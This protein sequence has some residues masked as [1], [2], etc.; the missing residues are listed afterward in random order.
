MNIFYTRNVHELLPRALDSL[1]KN[2][3][4]RNSRNGPVLQLPGP[5]LI[6]YECPQE[7][8]MFWPERDAN[9]FFHL[10]EA[11]WMLAG[12]E[13]VAYPAQFV[14]RISEY[15][16]DG[17]RFRGAYGFRWRHYFMGDQLTVIA[18]RLKANPDCRRQ[19]LTMWDGSLDLR[20]QSSKDL[21]CNT[22]IYFSV[23][24]GRLDMTVCNRSNDV[25]WGCLG[26][27]AV[28]M[29]VLQ[30]YMAGLIGVE[31]GK[32]H[33]FS[34]NLHGYLNTIEP[35][36]DLVMRQGEESPYVIGGVTPTPLNNGRMGSLFEDDLG[37]LG[38][39]E[40]YQSPFFKQVFGPMELAHR[41]FKEAGP[42]AAL[43]MCPAIGGGDWQVAAKEWLQRR[44][45]RR[46]RAEKDGVCYDS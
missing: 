9:P 35:L 44:V 11:M 45:E 15:S 42:K 40:Q 46:E 14:K 12:R 8:V 3:V 31:V 39:P 25:V 17:E 23:S 43:E 34:N 5:S 32:Y 28:H 22:H 6:C 27:N 29:S 10:A 7:R 19:V 41:K 37:N 13:D 21:P 2:G 4:R 18:E 1:F 26:A 30:E 16:D 33:Q 24:E 20:Y 38:A 36:K